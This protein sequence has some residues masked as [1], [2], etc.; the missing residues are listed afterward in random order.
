MVYRDV[1]H[2]RYMACWWP[3][4]GAVVFISSHLLMYRSA[5]APCDLLAGVHGGRVLVGLDN[6]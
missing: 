4:P 3:H 1:S 6:N 2:I 5:Q